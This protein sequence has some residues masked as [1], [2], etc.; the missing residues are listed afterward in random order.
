MAS[1]SLGLMN[2]SSLLVDGSMSSHDFQDRTSE[3]RSYVAEYCVEAV[4]NQTKGVNQN[5]YDPSSSMG[6]LESGL[7]PIGG[8]PEHPIKQ[9]SKFNQAARKI[10][11]SLTIV[12]E[13]LEKLGNC[14]WAHNN[15]IPI[16]LLSFHQHTHMSNLVCSVSLTFPPSPFSFLDSGTSTFFIQ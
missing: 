11:T 10:N 2:T 1:S 4:Q 9:R 7:G 6:N 14:M 12:M 8:D 16:F 15:T 5:G 13:R 3:F